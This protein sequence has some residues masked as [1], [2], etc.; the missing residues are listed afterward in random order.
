ML[1]DLTLKEITSLP[2]FGVA[3]LLATGLLAIG[4]GPSTGHLPKTVPA[5]GILTLDGKPV[6]GAQVV[7]VA[8][9]QGA[10]GAFGATDANG[11][12][13]LRAFEEKDGAIPGS[14][15]V[16]VS[17]TILTNLDPAAAANLDGGKPIRNDYGVPPKYTGFETSGLTATIPDSGTT[18]LKFELSSK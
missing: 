11:R 12:F 2:L 9:S 8:D 5:A 7:L 16:Q 17:K 4:C 13:S 18:D 1:G 6:D 14:Y 10:T 3:L 15:K